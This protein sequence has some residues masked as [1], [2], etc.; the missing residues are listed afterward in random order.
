MDCPTLRVLEEHEVSQVSGGLPIALA[1]P[2]AVFLNGMS[3]GFGA[4]VTPVTIGVAIGAGALSA[5]TDS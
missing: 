1:L 2:A 4:A 5:L 3:A